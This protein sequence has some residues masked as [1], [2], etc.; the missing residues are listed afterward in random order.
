MYTEAPKSVSLTMH[1]KKPPAKEHGARTGCR[2]TKRTKMDPRGPAMLAAGFIILI[3]GSRFRAIPYK[4]L[5]A[6]KEGCEK[7]TSSPDL[8]PS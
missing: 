4:G 8:H 5:L 7:P 1:Q 2:H 3:D 6:Q